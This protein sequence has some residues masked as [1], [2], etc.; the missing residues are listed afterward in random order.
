MTPSPRAHR[1]A[2]VARILLVAS[3]LGIVVV[4]SGPASA[5]QIGVN[6]SR[7]HT[8][9]TVSHGWSRAWSCD[10]YNYNA[11][12][13]HG[14]GIK[15]VDIRKS[16][17]PY[18]IKCYAETSGGVNANCSTTAPGTHIMSKHDTG[19]VYA[20]IGGGSCELLADGHGICDHLM[21]AI[22]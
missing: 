4:A 19:R 6:A 21:E 16:D 15:W 7:S 11:W 20:D 13:N 1:T 2:V 9:G 22:L 18:A 3:L 14:H 12:T 10:H 5:C 17:S 8:V